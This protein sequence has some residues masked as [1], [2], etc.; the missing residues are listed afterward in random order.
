MVNADA[1]VVRRTVLARLGVDESQT[2]VLYAPTY[3]D[4]L[5]TRTF[6]ATPFDALELE[7]LTTAAR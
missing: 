6:A 1:A 2:V 7:P 3:R 4:N 5:T